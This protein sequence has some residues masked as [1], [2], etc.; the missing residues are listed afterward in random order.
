MPILPQH[1]GNLSIDHAI[2]KQQFPVGCVDHFTKSTK[3]LF[4][5]ADVFNFSEVK[6]VDK[7]H[8]V[9]GGE[10]FILAIFDGLPSFNAWIFEVDAEL[11][12]DHV[13]LLFGAGE[14]GM[15]PSVGKGELHDVVGILQFEFAA[16][17]GPDFMG[18]VGG[19]DG[20]EAS[21]IDSGLFGIPEDL[22]VDE[23]KGFVEEGGQHSKYLLK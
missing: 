18:K 4:N 2:T 14:G 12:E 11:F 6:G 3:L 7:L 17:H 13:G 10:R 21:N 20:E 16:P 1:I 15:A 8:G 19:E 22:F 23:S 5:E 9:D